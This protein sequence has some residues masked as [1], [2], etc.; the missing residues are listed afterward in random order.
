MPML[1]PGPG[2]FT[3]GAGRAAPVVGLRRQGAG[4]FSAVFNGG[5]TGGCTRF[6]GCDGHCGC[7]AAG[8]ALRVAFCLAAGFNDAAAAFNFRGG[9]GAVFFGHVTGGDTVQVE[10]LRLVH[11]R[12]QVGGA[13]GVAVQKDRQRLLREQPR[14]ALLDIGL[15]AQLDGQRAAGVEQRRETFGQEC[16][17][18]GG[19]QVGHGGGRR[20]S[21]RCW[22]G[23]PG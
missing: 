4:G 1:R 6:S 16:S 3:P 18:G 8:L 22:I 11:Q 19:G 5:C 23:R 20:R 14:R 10:A 17:A 9:G 2:P 12:T 21:G 15:N 13:G 7:R